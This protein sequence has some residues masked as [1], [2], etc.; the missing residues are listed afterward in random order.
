MKAHELSEAQ[1]PDRMWWYLV[2]DR[3][4]TSCL[5]DP[6]YLPNP[7][8]RFREESPNPPQRRNFNRLGGA[9]NGCAD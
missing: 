8:L 6:G 5:L 4:D 2:W 9:P 7:Y 1:W 3:F